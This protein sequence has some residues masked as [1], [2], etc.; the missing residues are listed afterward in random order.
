[1]NILSHIHI[2]RIPHL[3]GVGRVI[4]R[5][6]SAHARCF[7]DA[8]HRM[9]VSSKQYNQVY[10]DLPDHW[11]MAS[12]IPHKSSTSLQQAKWVW[13]RKPVA[14]RF[15]NDIDVVYCPAE[16]YVPT[17]RAKLVCT[18][19]DVGV[20]EPDLYHASMHRSFHCYKWRLLFRQMEK[21]ADAVVTVSQFSAERIQEFFP[22]LASKVHVIY[23][24]PCAVFGST[25]SAGLLAEARALASGHPYILVPGGLA[26][27]KNAD[28]IL[29]VVPRI[30]KLLPCLR[31][32]VAGMNSETYVTRLDSLG[33][34]NVVL[35]GY[36][37]DEMLNA[38]YQQAAAV[39]FPSR[40][41][42][43]GMPVVEAM[44]SGAPVVASR[45]ASIPEVVDDAALLCGVDDA[46]GHV[47]ALRSIIETSSVRQDLC[48]R[49]GRRAK[50]FTWDSSARELENLF[51]S[52]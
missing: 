31:I 49:G 1:M 42:G 39:W 3:S 19:H 20:F 4:D 34:S 9:L 36:V 12:Y 47:E 38:L 40:Y 43:F 2:H 5:M 29:R 16:S 7:P 28:L 37:S 52:L 48:D 14:E 30:E 32:V 17:K 22:G 18:I 44:A 8:C 10:L 15:W 26:F 41:E 25:S 24:A 23:N 50:R 13:Q 6:L 51:K 21:Y 35:A 46:E 33:V 45:V 27:R 11:K